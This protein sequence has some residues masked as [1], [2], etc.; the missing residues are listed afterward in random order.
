MNMVPPLLNPLFMCP[1][2]DYYFI[3]SRA[4]ALKLIE[5]VK[6]IITWISG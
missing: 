3:E 1:T 4:A 2:T 6:Q 5:E